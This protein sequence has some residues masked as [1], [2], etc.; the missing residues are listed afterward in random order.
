MMGQLGHYDPDIKD[1]SL[2]LTLQISG[3]QPDPPLKYKIPLK[4]IC[5]LIFV[6]LRLMIGSISHMAQQYTDTLL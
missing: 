5:I 1:S 4:T 2:G 6:L 3:A